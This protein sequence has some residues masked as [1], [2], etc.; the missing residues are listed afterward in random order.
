MCSILTV[1]VKRLHV[2]KVF[3]LYSHNE[4]A[5]NF[6]ECLDHSDAFHAVK[7]WDQY[8]DWYAFTQVP[9]QVCRARLFEWNKAFVHWEEGHSGGF[10][11]V[12]YDAHVS[13]ASCLCK[14]LHSEKSKTYTLK[15]WDKNTT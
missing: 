15:I 1:G 10:I 9:V 13:S 14:E 2:T 4:T 3:D 7:A 6:C 12:K 8:S 5:L 11:I